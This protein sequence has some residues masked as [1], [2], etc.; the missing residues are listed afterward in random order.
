MAFLAESF[1]FVWKDKIKSPRLTQKSRLLQI[2]LFIVLKKYG[3]SEKKKS[4]PK[5]KNF[6]LFQCN[7]SVRTLWCFQKK[8]KKTIFDPEKVKKRA[9]KVAHNRPR[10]SFP[11]VQPRPQLTAQNW[12]SI[13]WYLWT[14]HLFSYLWCR[15]YL[16]L[17]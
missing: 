15:T 11:T 6:T 5:N 13:S 7:F 10:P 3:F 4:P 1:S 9:S 16:L 2:S 8:I 12:F 17:W 14:R